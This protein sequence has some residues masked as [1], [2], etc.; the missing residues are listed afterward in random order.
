[1]SYSPMR[2]YSNETPVE[3]S[4]CRNGRALRSPERQCVGLPRRRPYIDRILLVPIVV[5]HEL[6]VQRRA[7]DPLAAHVDEVVAGPI[8][9]VEPVDAARVEPGEEDELPVVGRAGGG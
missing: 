9:G 3:S 1:M 7:A 4:S 8:V 6:L 5:G 2:S